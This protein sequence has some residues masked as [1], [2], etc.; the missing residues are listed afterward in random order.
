MMQMPTYGTH[1]TNAEKYIGWVDGRKVENNRSERSLEATCIV[2]DMQ[3]S[4]IDSKRE[5][6]KITAASLL[7][8]GGP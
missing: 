3:E 5:K 6:R 8:H 7:Y 4:T 1:K 2:F